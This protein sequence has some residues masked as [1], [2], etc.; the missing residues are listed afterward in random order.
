MLPIDWSRASSADQGSPNAEVCISE[1]PIDLIMLIAQ[2]LA[3]TNPSNVVAIKASSMLLGSKT[4]T[5]EIKEDHREVVKIWEASS[6]CA[7]NALAGTTI[8]IELASSSFLGYPHDYGNH[9]LT[10]LNHILTIDM[11]YGTKHY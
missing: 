1:S 2:A 11:N 5:A 6:T 8:T 10:I 4:A 7:G 9:H 3:L